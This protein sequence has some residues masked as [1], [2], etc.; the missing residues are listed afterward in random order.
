MTLLKKED[1]IASAPQFDDSLE[2]AQRLRDLASDHSHEDAYM[3][4]EA[5]Q[6][7]EGMYSLIRSMAHHLK[8][9]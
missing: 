2:L 4:T 6:N 1:C 8:E 5:A 3:L 9:S 7:L